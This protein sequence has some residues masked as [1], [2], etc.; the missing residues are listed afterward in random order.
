MVFGRMV[1]VEAGKIWHHSTPLKEVFCDACHLAQRTAYGC[2]PRV[3]YCETPELGPTVGWWMSCPL[4]LGEETGTGA[5][6]DG[7]ILE[8]FWGCSRSFGWERGTY[9]V[10]VNIGV[11]GPT[12]IGKM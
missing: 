2:Q 1:H 8:R 5:W 9:G 11:L 10:H 7:M 6:L 4:Q 3:S 12:K